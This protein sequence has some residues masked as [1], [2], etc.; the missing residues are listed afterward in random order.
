MLG[1][2]QAED[3]GIR[4]RRVASRLSETRGVRQVR[5]ACDRDGVADFLIV[6]GLY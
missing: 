1:R 4:K 2:G 3:V 6:T 5:A